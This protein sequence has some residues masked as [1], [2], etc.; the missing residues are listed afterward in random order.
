M[1]ASRTSRG[2][3]SSFICSTLLS[4]WFFLSV[5]T[6]DLPINPVQATFGLIGLRPTPGPRIL[7]RRHRPGLRLASDALVAPLKQ[8]VYGHVVL[9]DVRVCPLLRHKGERR[10]LGCPVAL[11]PSDHLRVGSLGGLLSANTGHP[12]V[13]VLQRPFQRLYLPHLAAQV[14]AAGTHPLAV[15]LNLLPDRKLRSKHL[16]RQL[17]APHDLLAKLDGLPEKEAR[18]YGEDGDL[19]GNLGDHVYESHPLWPSKRGREREPV[20]VGRNSPLD[21]LPRRGSLQVLR[22]PRQLPWTRD[23]TG[24]S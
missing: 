5:S 22:L 19:V 6:Y 12:R 14:R 24:F 21:G 23:R 15:T 18:V 2:W 17:V 8:R 7:V 16:Q 1:I 13:I 4:F 20:A 9:G 10:D 11:F 3:R